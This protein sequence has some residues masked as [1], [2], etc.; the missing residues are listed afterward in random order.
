[1]TCGSCDLTPPTPHTQG[2]S[3]TWRLGGSS[4]AWASAGPAA[5]G[6]PARRRHVL[7]APLLL[8]EGDPPPRFLGARDG[9]RLRGPAL[10]RGSADS[11]V[12]A[13]SSG[14]ARRGRA[15]PGSAS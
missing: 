13:V 4:Q 5:P 2:S 10:A 11:L 1:M 8:L 3:E 14:G 9:P 6:G 12:E 7:Y 15:R